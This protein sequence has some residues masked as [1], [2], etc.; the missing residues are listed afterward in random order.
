LQAEAEAAIKL[1]LEQGLVV[2][3]SLLAKRLQ[4]A[5]LTLLQ[6]GQVVRDR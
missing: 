5:L 4:K 3:V 6:W 2:I 1:P